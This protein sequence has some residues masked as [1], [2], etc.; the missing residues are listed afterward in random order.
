MIANKNAIKRKGIKEREAHRR[1]GG[2]KEGKK[3]L[4]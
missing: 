2:K 3:L 4:M 1:R